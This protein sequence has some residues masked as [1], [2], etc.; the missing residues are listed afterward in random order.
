MISTLPRPHLPTSL[1]QDGSSHLCDVESSL[2]EHG[3]DLKTKNRH[4]Y[5]FRAKYIRVNFDIKVVL[6]AADLKFRLVSKGREII[7]H[8]HDVIQVKWEPATSRSPK[9]VASLAVLEKPLG[10]Y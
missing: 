1:Y 6:G 7:S 8:D 9:E 3:I 10:S 4:W 5:N 2:S